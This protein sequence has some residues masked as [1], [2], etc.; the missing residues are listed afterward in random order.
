MKNKVV[1]VGIT[2]GIGA[3][4][5]LI[6]NIF[7]H[8]G[9]PV[10][11]ADERAKWLMSHNYKLR[12]MII[13]HFG[14]ESYHQKDLNR[15]YLAK[16]VFNDRDKLHLLNSLVHPVV[17]DDYNS[18]LKTINF[19]YSIKEAALMFETG[20][21]RDMDM[22]IQVYAPINVRIARVLKRDPFR[23]EDDVKAIIGQQMDEEQKKNLADKIIMNDDRNMVL[24][25]ALEI[26][27]SLCD[28]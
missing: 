10:Y 17:R 20:S 7:S 14:P 28:R 12:D 6:C 1:Q 13:R 16:N 18:W 19:P 11:H 15:T 21:Y 27:R 25:V 2:G 9:A 26:H 23:T 5:T 22:C 8:L 24:P 4:K 3:G